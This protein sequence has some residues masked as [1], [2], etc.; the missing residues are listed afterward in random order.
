MHKKSI[1]IL[2]LFTIIVSSCRF[3]KEV[4]CPS[5]DIEQPEAEKK[6]KK[7]KYSIVILKDGKRINSKKRRNKSKNKLFRK[8]MY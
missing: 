3:K 8:K 7:S 1:F 5:F 2:L 6:K 4:S